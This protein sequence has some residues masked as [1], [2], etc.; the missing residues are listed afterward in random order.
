MVLALAACSHRGPVAPNGGAGP[1]SPDRAPATSE[2]RI[3]GRPS[4]AEAIRIFEG[5]VA[6]SPQDAVS[7]TILG[8]LYLR[9][10]KETGDLADYPKAET[11]LRK[12]LDLL[13]SYSPAKV[14]LAAALSM[15]HK[16]AETLKLAQ[17]ITASRPN[18]AGALALIG[19]AQ[20]E[21]GNYPD[22][23]NAYRELARRDSSAPALSRLAHLA[24]LQGRW[25]DAFQL[26]GRARKEA[27]EGSGTNDEKA[28]YDVRLGHLYLDN[29]NP[30]HA[31]RYCEEALE[32][33]PN[34]P[35]TLAGL[36]EVRAAQ[37]RYDDAI[38]LYRRAVSIREEPSSLIMLGDLY[39]VAGRMKEARDHYNRAEAFME[40]SPLR[41]A[42]RRELSLFYAD[43]D[44]KLDKAL[45]LAQADL[46]ARKDVY[47]YDTMAWALYKN[48]RLNEA[49]RVI[50][51]AMKL[52]TRSASL[53]Y[54]AG[55]IHYRLGKNGMARRYLKQAL[56]I[57]P[58]FS[59]LHEDEA[60]RALAALR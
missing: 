49:A 21:L 9:E 27:L 20:L 43:H 39:A 48:N 45:G 18:D 8:R 58:R 5:R 60:R 30:E 16:F 28:W 47:A 56:E 54:H 44:L 50:A 19:D 15:Q 52:G 7:Y 25:D 46:T 31:S 12:A 38:A 51:D 26:M 59:L 42:Y 32:L 6:R 23:E 29:G 3:A 4:T 33:S 11:A 24:E 57:N 40:N 41:E 17:D 35:L 10:A 2:S 14:P 36:G 13:P 55:M 34:S 53:Y 22:A 1:A 37:K